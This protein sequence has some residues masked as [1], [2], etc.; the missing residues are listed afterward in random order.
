MRLVLLLLLS[1]WAKKPR[2]DPEP[3]EAPPPVPPA[4]VV[5]APADPLGELDIEPLPLWTNPY[6]KNTAEQ[7]PFLE[8]RK[9]MAKEGFTRAQAV[10]A[11]NLLR[12]AVRDGATDLAA[13]YADAVAKVRAG[14]NPSA[15]DAAALDA[16]PFIVAFD[17]D[18]TLIDQTKG[19]A[20]FAATCG[21]LAYDGE[22]YVTGDGSKLVQLAPAWEEAFRAV[23]ESGGAIVLFS[24]NLDQRVR[25][26][27]EH[28]IWEGKTIAEHPDIQGVLSNGDLILQTRGDAEKRVVSEPSKDLRTLDT[29]M[30]RV[31]LVD[32]NP[33]RTFQPSNLRLTRKFNAQLYCDPKSHPDVKAALAGELRA[34]ANEI[35]DAAAWKAN[36]G[37]SFKA[38]FLPYSQTGRLA[39]DAL[40]SAKGWDRAKAVAFVRDHP[41]LVDNAF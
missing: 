31:I 8:I 26:L 4:P 34:V 3:T 7:G 29:S 37:G 22:P 16:A 2:P 30:E 9:V 14:A 18:E 11:Q 20:T 21:P 25:G 19:A 15:L 5:V 1:A 40:V 35:R 33:T 41:E 28:W 39:V 12:D 32:D 6:A 17:L 24:A 13:A 10:A 36:H 27:I 23:R 38:A